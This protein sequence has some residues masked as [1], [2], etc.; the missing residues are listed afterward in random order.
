MASVLNRT[1]KE[2]RASA[3]TPDFPEIDWIINPDMSAVVGFDSRYW[4]IT[5]DVVSLMAEVDRTALDAAAE[6]TAALEREYGIQASS[7]ASTFLAMA[8]SID[9]FAAS[10]SDNIGS[11]IGSLRDQETAAVDA[12]RAMTE[13]EGDYIATVVANFVEAGGEA[14]SYADEL[15]RIPTEVVTS[16]VTERVERGGGGGNTGS[17]GGGMAM[18]AGGGITQA[19]VPVVVGEWG[20][21]VFIPEQDGRILSNA[22]ADQMMNRGGGGSGPVY[23]ITVNNSDIRDERSLLDLLRTQE[24]LRG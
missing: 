23:N 5:G 10:G 7:S 13:M 22:Q 16:I 1:T 20:R 19:G 6:I 12:Q 4:V 15:R 2:Y 18:R 8:G 21:E 9:E 11:L 14:A 17:I 24:L 3:N